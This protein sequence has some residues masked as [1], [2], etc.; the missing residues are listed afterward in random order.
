MARS[1]AFSRGGRVGQETRYVETRPLQCRCTPFVLFQKDGF[2]GPRQ[3]PFV[4]EGRPVTLHQ[5]NKR[6]VHF[7]L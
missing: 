1:G 3:F 6:L 2:S 4:V 7:S 5:C